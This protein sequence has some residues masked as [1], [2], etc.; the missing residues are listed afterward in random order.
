MSA[1]LDE[2][3]TQTQP[4][5]FAAAAAATEAQTD[6]PL[7]TSAEPTPAAG[8]TAEQRAK[9][10]AG[11]YGLTDTEYAVLQKTTCKDAPREIAAWFMLFCLHRRL[12]AFSKQVYLFNDKRD[13]SGQWHV[14]T[15]IDGLRVIA[16]RS[17]YYRGQLK[18]VWTFVHDSDESD[19]IARFAKTESQYGKIE[20]KRVPEECEVVVRRA[21]PQAPTDSSLYLDFYGIARFEEFCKYNYDGKIFGNWEVQPE[22]QTRIRAEA[23]GLRMGFPEEVGG[24]YLEDEIRDLRDRTDAVALPAGTPL[25]TVD[26]QPIDDEID[27]LASAL[28]YTKARVRIEADK[29]G[30]GKEG[31]RDALAAM[32][33]A[34]DD[35]APK[36]AQK[37]AGDAPAV[38]IT[39]E[40]E[41]VEPAAP[42]A[43]AAVEPEPVAPV[44]P[45]AAPKRRRGQ[46]DDSNEPLVL[47]ARCNA[48]KAKSGERHAPNCP[49]DETDMAE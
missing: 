34:R 41:T 38:P 33:A 2:T 40:G 4:N 3:Q 47:L 1:T 37:G 22:H 19:G 25:A 9:K 45:V 13:N 35:A 32:K 31:L 20:G 7:A 8:E 43:D 42:V 6:A 21:I 15:G 28:G 26:R 49:I 39:L 18:P 24:I 46:P 16:S 36:G 17:P 44:V 5:S 11:A 27:A 48:C 29:A 10:V 30:G 23:M 12:D 14:V